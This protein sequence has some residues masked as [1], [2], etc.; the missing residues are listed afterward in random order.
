MGLSRHEAQ[1][2][3]ELYGRS[4]KA[5]VHGVYSLARMNRYAK[6]DENST[7]DVPK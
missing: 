5:H 1:E 2:F 3:F 4:K 6:R 7:G